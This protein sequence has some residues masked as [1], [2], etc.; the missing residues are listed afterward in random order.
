LYGHV[1]PLPR[2]L[3]LGAGLDAIPLVSIADQLGWQTTIMDHREAYLEKA[4]F[5][6]LPNAVH[7]QPSKLSATTDLTQFS[8]A[9]VMSHHLAS[10]RVYLEQ[11]APSCIPYVGVL[12]PRARR[13]RLVADLSRDGVQ[14]LDRIKGP[15]GLDIG[16]DCAESIALSILAEVYQLLTPAGNVIAPRAHRQ[17]TD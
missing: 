13:D 11:L 3:V 8:A 10:D 4:G 6:G 14:G 15:I 1:L 2:M 7:I 5:T 16:A 9:I 12:G 17:A